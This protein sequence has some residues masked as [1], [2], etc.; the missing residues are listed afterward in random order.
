MGEY[1]GWKTIGA[2]G[3]AVVTLAA[4][5]GCAAPHQITDRS[6]FL[7][8][9]TRE[10]AGET[11]ERVIKAAETVLRISDPSDFEF[12]YN[13]NGFEGLRRYFIYAV[14][15]SAQGREKWD[16]VTEAAPNGIR[17]SVSVSEAGVTSGGYSRQQY[18]SAMASVPAVLESRRLHAGPQSRLDHVRRGSG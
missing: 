1:T 12:R 8:E 2:L 10:Y 3:V 9:G 6:D 11:K 7:A 13:L 18:E 16:F 14:L 4:L 17:A 5:G 15:A